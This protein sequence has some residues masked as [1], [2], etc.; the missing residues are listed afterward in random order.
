MSDILGTK[1]LYTAYKQSGR[2]HHVHITQAVDPEG[3]K[4]RGDGVQ[5]I[6]FKGLFTLCYG[7]VQSGADPPVHAAHWS[8]LD[9]GKKNLQ[10]IFHST[11]V[12]MILYEKS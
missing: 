1:S 9:S 7:T 10:Y 5:L 6:G 12:S 11:F 4:G 3:V 2:P 8:R